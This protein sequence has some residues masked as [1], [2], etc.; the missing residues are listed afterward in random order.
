MEKTI[1]LKMYGMD[2]VAIKFLICRYEKK[3]KRNFV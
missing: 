2:K 1:R 3:H